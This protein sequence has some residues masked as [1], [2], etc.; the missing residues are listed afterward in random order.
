MIIA[1]TLLLALAAPITEAL[2]KN[3]SGQCV[4]VCVLCLRHMGKLGPLSPSCRPDL[5]NF[6]DVLHVFMTGAIFL[7]GKG[8]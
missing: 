3:V 6:D 5:F 4:C 2:H 7:L 1:G 8:L